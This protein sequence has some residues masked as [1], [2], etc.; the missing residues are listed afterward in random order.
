MSFYFGDGFDHYATAD[1]NLKWDTIDG[2][3]PSNFAIEPTGGRNGKGCGSFLKCYAVKNVAV[4]NN[5]IVGFAIKFDNNGTAANIIIFKDTTTNNELVGVRWD[6]DNLLKIINPNSGTILASSTT[7]LP[8][9]TWNY[10]EFKGSIG[11]SIASNS[12]E[13]RINQ[14]LEATVA[15]GTSTL[16]GSAT[17]MNSIQVGSISGALNGFTC[18]IDDCVIINVD[19]AVAPTDFIGDVTGEALYPN[20]QGNYSDFSPV[21]ST[22]HYLCVNEH[23]A[24]GDTTYVY[25]NNNGSRES[26]TFPGTTDSIASVKALQFVIT[27]RKQGSGGRKVTPFTRTSGTDY[28]QSDQSVGGSYTMSRQVITTNPATS[29]AWT[30]SEIASMES[31]FKT[32]Q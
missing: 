31:G 24:D 3:V 30:S 9:G 2:L 32:S 5:Y 29:A 28:D 27:A 10:V 11:S 6:T 16:W 26:Y 20:A 4:A 23:P 12:C 21:G 13:L 22:Q 15:A 17:D 14:S 18:H 1:V 7:V 25:S 19:D 8:T